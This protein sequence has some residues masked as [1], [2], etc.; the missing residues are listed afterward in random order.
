LTIIADVMQAARGGIKEL[1]LSADDMAELRAALDDDSRYGRPVEGSFF[2]LD[3]WITGRGAAYRPR[4][5]SALEAA[6][7]DDNVVVS[8]RAA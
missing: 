3:V 6:L 2:L 4:P 8:M 5:A 1:A 7:A